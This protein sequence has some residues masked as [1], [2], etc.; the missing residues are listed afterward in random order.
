MKYRRCFFSFFLFF[1]FHAFPG[2]SEGA[3]LISVIVADTLDP[4]IGDSTLQ[5]FNKMRRQMHR[6]AAYTNLTFKEVVLQGKKTLPTKLLKSLDSLK[7]GEEDVVFFFF[8]GH[9][10]RTSEKE[11]DLWPN[12]YFSQVGQGVD[13]NVIAKKLERKGPRFLI[14]MTDVCNSWI[15]DEEAPPLVRQGMQS[16]VQ[17][18]WIQ[19]NYRRLFLD[20]RGTIWVT[21]SWAGEPSWGTRLG[22]IF[23]SAFLRH[24]TRVIRE[25]ELPTWEMV[26]TRVSLEV[27][28]MQHPCWMI[29]PK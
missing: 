3:Q 5:D 20:T 6:I 22:G 17:D 24:L 21:S 19:A 13:F 23:T 2:I 14:V 1:V 16:L 10:F 28:E 4:S 18:E 8:S 7:V 9:G 12:L 25:C 15:P 27:S 11:G 29:I 26:L